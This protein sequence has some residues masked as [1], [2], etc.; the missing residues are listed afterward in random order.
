M[1]LNHCYKRK[2]DL[3]A[4]YRKALHI[5]QLQSVGV[6]V[7]ETYICQ[8]IVL[9]DVLRCSAKV[10]KW[11][12]CRYIPLSWPDCRCTGFHI[13]NYGDAYQFVLQFSMIKTF[14]SFQSFWT[15]VPFQHVYHQ[16]NF[17]NYVWGT[18]FYTRQGSKSHMNRKTIKLFGDLDKLV[19]P[20]HVQA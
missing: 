16:H 9:P 12:N 15:L 6:S 4:I 14:P 3:R 5:S 13:S 8:S 10:S 17:G 1:K 7:I 11:P 2:L 18:T 19:L 20:I